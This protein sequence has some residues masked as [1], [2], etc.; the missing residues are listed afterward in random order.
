MTSQALHDQRA[1]NGDPLLV[2]LAGVAELA[3]VRRPVASMWRTR[4]ASGESA[5][6]EPVGHVG[7]ADAFD[8]VE[9]AEWLSR[10][11]HGN[12]PDAKV[13][14]AA[15]ATPA[16]F[17]FADPAAV[18]E[19]EG[20]IA[21]SVHCGTLATLTPP[22]VREAAASADPN[23]DLLR[24]EALAHADRGA[25]WLDF[26]D[27]LVDAA[28]S[29]SA[30]LALVER[31]RAAL[32]GSAGSAGP[33]GSDATALI[34]ASVQALASND[35][36]RVLLHPHD[37]ELT[38]AI[39]ASVGDTVSLTTSTADAR[40]VRRRLLA[41]GLWLANDTEAASRTVVTA[42]VPSMRSDDVATMLRAIDEISLSLRDDDAAVVIG[43]ARVL[44]DTL[45]PSAE[46]LR[47]DVL[48]SGRVR[49]IARLTQGL[50]DTAPRES[51]ALWV[52]GSPMV[53]VAIAER[54]TVVA[55]LSDV[56]LTPATRA[57]LVSD[58]VASMG[59]ARE[60]RA[61]AFRFATF[62][63][64]ASLLARGGSLVSSG[65]AKPST[66]ASVT[67]LPALLDAAAK[68][69]SPSF[70]P[71]AVAPTGAKVPAPASIAELVRDGH[72]RVIPGTR[73]APDTTGP[74]G[75]AVVTAS[76]LDNPRAIGTTRVDQLVF[77]AQHPSATLSRPGDVIFRTAPTAA[78]WVDTDGSKVVS[79]PARILRV[80]AGD[81]GGLVPEVIA[82]DI[83][84][85]RSGPGA[86]KRWVLRRVAPHTIEQLR[87]ALAEIAAARSE[88]ETRVAG[89]ND[90]AALIVAG[91]TS[92]AVTILDSP[93]AASA[94]STH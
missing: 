58:V 60:V 10:T 47:A 87:Q 66:Q 40:G 76:D 67:D 56:P 90:Y 36:T 20:I 72:L 78:A 1:A 25:P 29:A 94:A 64:T 28:Y 4:F 93:H 91:A 16:D 46:R 22:G 86:W 51:L 6:P 39:A 80:T 70:A 17:S 53:A 32:F 37:A 15:A 89:L 21:L 2:T 8:V 82:A 3:H 18:A 83:T 9:V 12:N 19:L 74:E 7:G 77:A 69:V 92:G 84:G 38:M 35:D 71:I 13:D 88:L 73:L 5:F 54:F 52:L 27:R 79:Y 31:R 44:T 42:R 85:A 33:L 14:A 55:D 63:R 62:A 50:V 30:A 11:D 48:R 24:A 75:L 59:T 43:P 81:P 61:H 49:G 68:S 34:A 41:E 26:A 65:K 45:A 23:D 57:D